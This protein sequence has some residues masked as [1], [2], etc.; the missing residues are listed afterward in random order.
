MAA[1]A[2]WRLATSIVATK[3]ANPAHGLGHGTVGPLMLPW[4]PSH[5]YQAGRTVGTSHQ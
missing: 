4:S 5:Q 1:L 3:G 2:R